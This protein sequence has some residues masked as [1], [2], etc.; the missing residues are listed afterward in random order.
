MDGHI[1]T[2][3]RARAFTL[4]ELLVA[5]AVIAT[6]IGIL[7]PAMG[8]AREAARRVKCGAN[9]KSLGVAFL[10][11]IREHEVP[12]P[13]NRV[14]IAGKQEVIP[15]GHVMLAGPPPRY[16]SF[17]LLKPYLPGVEY[18]GCPSSNYLLPE[19]VLDATWKFVNGAGAGP[20]AAGGGGGGL[21]PSQLD[22]A[23]LYRGHYKLDLVERLGRPYPRVIDM[24]RSYKEQY[25]HGGNYI[26]VL[27]SDGHV[28]GM[29]NLHHNSDTGEDEATT[30]ESGSP[31]ELK[32]VFD[33]VDRMTGVY[34]EE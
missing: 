3:N 6:L 23:L 20:A 18:F 28:E 10:N 29:A 13:G 32:R 11:Y 30:I 33:V 12:P 8:Q 15:A 2:V 7:M 31:H 34:R 26:N 21:G 24:N 19:E 25:N 27:F 4:L 5:I 16:S 22:S 9:M 17:G 14:V 1:R